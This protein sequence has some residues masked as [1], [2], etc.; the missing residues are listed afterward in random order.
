MSG[1]LVITIGGGAASH[2]GF[3]A[4][5][6]V[7]ER[8]AATASRL[9]KRALI[10]EYLR[11][12]DPENVARGALYL[13]GLP[14][15]GTDPRT[16][17]IGGTLLTRVVRELTGADQQAMH[18]AYLRHGD[19]GSAAYD[20]LAY[21]LLGLPGGVPDAAS[22]LPRRAL[23]QLTL[24]QLTLND[25]EDSFAAIAAAPQSRPPSSGLRRSF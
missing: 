7:C 11:S 17:N 3:S 4:L 23:P 18:A 8:L 1:C 12:L 5:A 20:L 21:D 24:P 19:L 22:R 14:F 25:I 16:L 6:A 15:A 10:V 2:P 9:E 13:A